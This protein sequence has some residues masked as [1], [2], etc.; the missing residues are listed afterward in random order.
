MKDEFQILTFLPHIFTLLSEGRAMM[1]IISYIRSEHLAEGRC[2][3]HVA[4]KP[5]IHNLQKDEAS[6]SCDTNFSWS[7]LISWFKV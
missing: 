3:A 6:S 2:W 1:Y 4:P 7:Y 5:P